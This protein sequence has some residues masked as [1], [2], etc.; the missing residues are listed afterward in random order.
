MVYRSALRQS[1][2]SLWLRQ[3]ELGLPLHAAR[4]IRVWN[5]TEKA[6]QDRT[7]HHSRRACYRLTQAHFA[8]LS[9]ICRCQI[10][11]HLLDHLPHALLTHLGL[12]I[13]PAQD[14]RVAWPDTPHRHTRARTTWL[15]SVRLISSAL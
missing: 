2:L 11:G 7:P 15:S 12:Q 4:L 1:L 9:A 10:R 5:G 14:Q 3:H 6:G 8:A 13:T